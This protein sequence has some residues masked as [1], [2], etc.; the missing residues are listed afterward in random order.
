MIR[1]LIEL[2]LSQDLRHNAIEGPRPRVCHLKRLSTNSMTT[3]KDHL[4]S[5]LSKPTPRIHGYPIQNPGKG[6]LWGDRVVSVHLVR[7][8]TR[9]TLL[10]L[11]AE[12]ILHLRL[13]LRLLVH[14]YA[15]NAP[16]FFHRRSRLPTWTKN[17]GDYCL[18]NRIS[19]VI[20]HSRRCRVTSEVRQFPP[21]STMEING[22][23]VHGLPYSKT[24]FLSR[25]NPEARSGS[26]P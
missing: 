12:R 4:P 17:P 24:W 23:D 8:V 2:N 13:L 21:R 25:S 11:R 14:S 19:V 1:R 18:D 5:L 22:G 20:P 26:R 6:G 9:G 16:P 15:L 10:D 7:N 3:L